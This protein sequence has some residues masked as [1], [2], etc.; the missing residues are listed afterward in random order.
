[1][2]TTNAAID[3]VGVAR[4]TRSLFAV[5]EELTPGQQLVNNNEP[6][7]DSDSDFDP[8]AN[9][10][11]D[12]VVND[13]KIDNDGDWFFDPPILNS[14]Q[15]NLEP[16]NAEESKL[17]TVMAGQFIIDLRRLSIPFSNVQAET[18]HEPLVLVTSDALASI[19]KDRTV[20]ACS[21]VTSQVRNGTKGDVRAPK[22]SKEKQAAAKEKKQKQKA[23]TRQSYGDLN[24]TMA[25][26]EPF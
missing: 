17:V 22:V 13:K 18:P 3:G 14:G 2:K 11:M 26:I 23:R 10:E 7:S 5:T 24:K 8:S 16:I 6:D 4:S 15:A 21:W 9:E 20:S 25:L 19:E 1:M 12:I